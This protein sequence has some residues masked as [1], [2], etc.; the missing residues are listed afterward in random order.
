MTNGHGPEFCSIE[1]FMKQQMGIE[2]VCQNNYECE[3]NQCSNGKCVDI[4]Q[5]ME[6]TQ[7][8]LKTIIRWLAKWF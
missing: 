3:S 4:G 8:M 2:G 1:G 6:E 5:Q 7:S